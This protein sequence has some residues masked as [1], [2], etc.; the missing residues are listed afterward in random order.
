MNKKQLAFQQIAIAT[1]TLA[2]FSSLN[3]SSLALNLNPQ[4]TGRFV[5]P[6][7][8]G[9]G[10]PRGRRNG[11]AGRQD[12]PALAKPLTALIPEHN[13][14][15][16]VSEPSLWF[17]VPQLP[18]T[19]N[20]GEFVLQDEKHNDLY[21]T[22]FKLPEKAGIVSIRLP[23]NLLEKDQMYRWHFRIYC[24]SQTTSEYFWVEGWVKQVALNPSLA[25]QIEAAKPLE[26]LV[27]A[28]NGIWYE[29]LT[30]LAEL[31][32]SDPQ[33]AT[34]RD[35]WT[36]LLQSVGLA[37]L[38]QEPLLGSVVTQQDQSKPISH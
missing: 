31:R 4:Q 37:E 27:Y 12:C 26:Y 10:T 28:A 1:T 15:L 3:N 25:T 32:L 13:L 30:K 7:P 22:L 34:L 36:Q 14:G 33:N 29:A 2:V 19:T 17:F 6:P 8:S 23:S 9:A 16:T 20:S 11:G 5:P 38:A 21:R 24:Q 18:T 35:H